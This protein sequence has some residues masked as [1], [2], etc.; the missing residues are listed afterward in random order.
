MY[1]SS[2]S[3]SGTGVYGI[4]SASSGFPVIGVLGKSCSTLGYGVSGW[5]SASSGVTCGVYGASD[6]TSGYGVFAMATATSGTTYAVVGQSNSSNGVSIL[7]QVGAPGAKP[8]VARGF[9]GQTANLQAWQDNSGTALSVVDRNGWFGVGIT[10]AL[11]AVRGETSATGFAGLYGVSLSEHGIGV[12]GWVKD[13]TGIPFVAQGASG[14]TA[15]LQEWWNIDKT[16][17]SVVDKDDEIGAGTTSPA[18]AVHGVSS[19]GVCCLLVRPLESGPRCKTLA[20]ISYN[21]C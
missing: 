15:N 18:A 17:L 14:H 7:G 3:T 8:I 10:S 11:A 13:P 21:S 5:A 19:S 2:D 4:A 12:I 6:S 20:R 1:G 9:S 16:A